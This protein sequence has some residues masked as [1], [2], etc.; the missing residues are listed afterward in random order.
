MNNIYLLWKLQNYDNEILK[1]KNKLIDSSYKNKI[2]DTNAKISQY[3]FELESLK[4]KIEV[5][6]VKISRN[7]N[8]LDQIKFEINEINDKLYSGNT[9]NMNELIYLQNKA[10]ELK[11]TYDNLEND[12]IF[13]MEE[14]EKNNIELI[15]LNKKYSLI[16]REI[17]NYKKSIRENTKLLKDKLNE[18]IIKREDILKNIEK[19]FLVEYERIKNRN[20]NAVVLVKNNICSGCHMEIPLYI[21]SRLHNND[22][23]I[24]CD[25]CGRILFMERKN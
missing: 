5:D 2:N 7:N 17:E 25:N 16:K 6:K 22:S 4:T 10:N 14:V 3:K 19:D 9:N 11:I 1:I 23:I 18:I 8:K 12:T 20:K 24:R 15:K 13:L 21:L